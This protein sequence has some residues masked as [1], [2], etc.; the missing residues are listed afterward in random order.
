MICSSSWWRSTPD[1][2]NRQKCR[3][4]STTDGSM[5]GPQQ[6]C[7]AG[8]AKTRMCVYCIVLVLAQCSRT[9]DAACSTFVLPSVGTRGRVVFMLKLRCVGHVVLQRRF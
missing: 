6:D 2:K 1:H 7:I 5:K 4:R 3:A 9:R 8:A